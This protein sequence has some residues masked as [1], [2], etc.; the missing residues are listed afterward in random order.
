MAVG[1]DE[2]HIAL[3]L[4]YALG[5]G[6]GFGGGGGFVEQRGAG[7]V[8]AGEV[9]GQ[10]LEVQQRLQAALGDFRLVGGVGGVPARVLQHVAQDDGG[11]DGAVVAGADQAGPE[12]VLLRIPLQLGQRGLLVERG[13]QVQRAVQADRRRDGLDDQLITA[14][15]AERFEHL[16]LLGLVGAEVAAEEGVGLVQLGK[17][18]RMRHGICLGRGATPGGERL[19]KAHLQGVDDEKQGP[20]ESRPC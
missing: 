13:G 11:G 20:D 15:D 8:E 19:R 3:G 5:Q 14:G 7:Q 9:D 10:L 2:E 1:I 18:R 12:L 16:A 6:H 4:R 17:R